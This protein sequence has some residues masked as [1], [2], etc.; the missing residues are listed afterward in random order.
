MHIRPRLTRLGRHSRPI[1]HLV[2]LIATVMPVAPGRAHALPE[3]G[4]GGTEPRVTTAEPTRAAFDVIQRPDGL[5]ESVADDLESARRRTRRLAHL[6]SSERELV[7]WA[8]Q[9][10]VAAGLQPPSPDIAFSH[11]RDACGG[12]NGRYRPSTGLVSICVRE[13]AGQLFRRTLMLHELAH[14]WAHHTLTAEDRAAFVQLRGAESWRDQDDPWLERGSE[15]AAEVLAWGLMDV[16]VDL[17]HFEQSDERSLVVAFTM[18]TGVS[19]INDGSHPA[20]DATEPSSRPRSLGL[21]AHSSTSIA[22]PTPRQR[23]VDDEAQPL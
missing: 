15:H 18:L 21:D 19:P 8:E 5:D 1:T 17:S 9:R 20:H 3:V 7:T 14:A 12:H 4:V 23:P 10:F 16:P 22:S 2:V 11:D 6:T 13:I